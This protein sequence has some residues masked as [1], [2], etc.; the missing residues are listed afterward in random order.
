VQAP[1]NALEQRWA[2][3]VLELRHLL[4]DRA[5]GQVQFL[6]RAGEA[7]VA[8]GGLEALQGGGGRHQAFGHGE[9]ATRQKRKEFIPNR[10]MCFEKV[11]C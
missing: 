9:G 4:A 3:H 1:A 8:G 10:M 7:Q 5:L 6:R 2:K 11:V